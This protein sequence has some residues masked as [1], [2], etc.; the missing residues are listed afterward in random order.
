MTTMNL[1]SLNACLH[2]IASR[3]MRPIDPVLI[4][5]TESGLFSIQ[6]THTDLDPQETLI[7]DNLDI[8]G[9]PGW[10]DHPD[11]TGIYVADPWELMKFIQMV[12][13]EETPGAANTWGQGIADP[14]QFPFHKKEK[15]T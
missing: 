9:I 2:Q 10:T 1:D 12:F 3:T 5:D 15:S 7:A 14:L 8:D 6:S 11:P 4:L 13:N